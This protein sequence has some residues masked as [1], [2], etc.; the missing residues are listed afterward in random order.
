MDVGSSMRNEG[1]PVRG[2]SGFTSGSGMNIGS[3][4]IPLWSSYTCVTTIQSWLVVY[5]GL[6]QDNQIILFGD[7]SLSLRDVC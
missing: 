3:S 1:G 4:N 6:T 5:S 2:F 7:L